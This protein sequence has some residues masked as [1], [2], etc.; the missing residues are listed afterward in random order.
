[1]Y[2]CLLFSIVGGYNCLIELY[3]IYQD[4]AKNYPQ[5][6]SDSYQQNNHLREDSNVRRQDDL[7]SD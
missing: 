2:F 6:S 3:E 5:T 4:E 1:M 7:S